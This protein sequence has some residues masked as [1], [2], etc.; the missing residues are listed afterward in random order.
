MARDHGEPLAGQLALRLRE[1]VLRDVE[2]NSEHARRFAVRRA[3]NDADR[4]EKPPPRSILRAHPVLAAVEVGAAGHD[5]LD[6][7]VVGSTVVGMK[8]TA[9]PPEIEALHLGRIA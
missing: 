4:A 6:A 5:V 8:Q 9:Q 2:L 3:L 7:A 1:L